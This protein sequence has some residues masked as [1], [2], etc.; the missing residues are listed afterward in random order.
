MI[1]NGFVKFPRKMVEREWF[2]DGSTLIVYVFL[3]C[4]AA[5]NDM[6]YAGRTLHRGQYITSVKNLSEKCRLS[7]RQTRTALDHLQTTKDI[8]ISSTPKFSI[9]TV[10]SLCN[11]A[12]GDTPT[13][14]LV[15]KLADKQNDN[16]S[17]SKEEVSK[18]KIIKGEAGAASPPAPPLSD[19]ND[20][21]FSEPADE[22]KALVETYGE[23]AVALYENKFRKWSAKKRAVNVSMYP[24]IADWLAQDN[25]GAKQAD[26]RSSLDIDEIERALLRQYSK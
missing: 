11:K 6:E 25:V 20:S 13:D 19:N 22:R 5:F 4:A 18:E 16:I 14:K 15:D 1:E 23:S 24:T 7:V 12:S 3:L 26:S 9:I 2:G 21:S 17:R 10:N 8:T